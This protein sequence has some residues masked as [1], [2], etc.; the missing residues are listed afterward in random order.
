MK[1]GKM[2]EMS[3]AERGMDEM[4][5]PA[6]ILSQPLRHSQARVASPLYIHVY[7]YMYVF[8]YLTAL[9]LTCCSMWDRTRIPCF[10]SVES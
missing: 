10:E 2:E 6:P 9:G 5:F 4:E 1:T 3:N 7:I 8:V